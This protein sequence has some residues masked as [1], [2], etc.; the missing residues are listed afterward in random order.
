MIAIQRCIRNGHKALALRQKGKNRRA[1]MRDDEIGLAQLLIDTRL[2]TKKGT[3][4]GFVLSRA[5]LKHHRPGQPSA[6][7][8]F[9]N[10]AN[11]CIEVGRSD[12]HEDHN[13][14]PW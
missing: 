10:R 5:D 11:Q 12:R 1:A 6:P 3:M 7:G 4:N 9:I 8:K 14:H 2:E 13:T